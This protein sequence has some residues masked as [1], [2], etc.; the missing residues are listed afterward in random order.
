MMAILKE[1]HQ[2]Q[3][4]REALALLQRTEVKLAPLAGGTALIGQLEAR[5]QRNLDGVVDLSA[6]GLR[7]IQRDGDQLHIGATTTLTDLIEHPSVRNLAGGI[8]R[9]TAQAEGPVNLRNAAT[10]GGIVASAEYDSELYA[11]LLAL[12]AGV[13]LSTGDGTTTVPFAELPNFFVTLLALEGAPCHLVTEI[14][15]SL[16][17]GYSGHARVARTPADRPIV[18]AVAVIGAEGEQVALC[19]VAERPVLQGTPLNPPD[20]F[21]GSASYRQAMAQLM[22]TRA[23]AE[24][25]KGA[26]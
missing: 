14:Q 24:A 23:L 11:A 10:I 2:P 20:N 7:Y 25:H 4:L 12:N 17:N 18:A 19:G 21:K 15:L 16:T 6:L 1:Y 13:T 22:V 8:L 9:R 3:T 5:Q 26:A